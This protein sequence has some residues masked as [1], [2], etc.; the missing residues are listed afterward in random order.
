M[1]LVMAVGAGPKELDLGRKQELVNL[2]V[3]WGLGMVW[4]L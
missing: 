3:G 4:G 1:A 2:V